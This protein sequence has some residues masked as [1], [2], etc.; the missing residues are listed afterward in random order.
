[1]GVTRYISKNKGSK[2]TAPAIG[3]SCKAME[4]EIFSLI[5]QGIQLI[6]D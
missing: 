1:M 5:S 4:A 2:N 3:N 6:T